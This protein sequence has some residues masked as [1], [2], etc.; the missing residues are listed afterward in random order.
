MR[1]NADN[2]TRFRSLGT[3]LYDNSPP[4]PKTSE[5]RLLDYIDPSLLAN[6]ANK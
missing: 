5:S 1:Y 3:V 4:V 6:E 2:P